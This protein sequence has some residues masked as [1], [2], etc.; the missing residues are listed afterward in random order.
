MNI[1]I[2]Q[3]DLNRIRKHGEEDYPY[4]CCGFLFG[5]TTSEAKSVMK[6]HPVLNSRDAEN[7]HN[8]YLITP[9]EFLKAERKAR[10]EG[11]DI[12]GFYHSHPDAEARPSQYDLDYSWPVY[13]YLIVSVKNREARAATSWKIKDDR[14][15]FVEEKIVIATVPVEVG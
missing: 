14:S 9:Q 15:E 4:E 7:R 3:S 10:D 2:S 1:K 8:R 5:E 12:I 6:V 13:S 11:L